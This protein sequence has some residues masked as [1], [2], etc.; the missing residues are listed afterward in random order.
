MKIIITGGMGF[1]G[2]SLAAKLL[3][4]GH[5]VISVGRTK[6]PPVEKMLKGLEYFSCN[7]AE[8]NLPKSVLSNTDVVFH[9]AA[10]AGVGG[11]YEEYHSANYLSTIRILKSCHAYG[12]R[13]FIQT[14]T[15]SVVF[16]N[17]PIRN[18]DER[19]PYVESSSAPYPFTKALAEKQVLQAH[20]PPHFQ[21]ISLRPHLVWGPGDQHLLP[22]VLSR[23]RK[24]KLK[25]IGK[26][27][28]MVDLT[29]ID[30]VCH[31][32]LLVMKGMFGNH[33]MGGKPYF[34]GQSEPVR[35]WDWINEIFDHLNL[36][37]LRKKVSFKKAYYLG[38]LMEGLWNS[39]SLQQDPPMTRFVASQL[40]HDHWFSNQDALSDFGYRPIISMDDAMRK[41]LPWLKSL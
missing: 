41:T 15:P 39:L 2:N 40:A 27:D 19:L 13:K 17:Q 5:Q 23:H 18:G 12:V 35:L 21:T 22:R 1:I 37:I 14:S 33:N 7:L 36:P 29:H 11:K 3:E 28:N 6:Q 38:F 32:H 30:N 10:K 16:S 20:N 8:E 9:T 31:A 25:I 4:E 24:G 26:G 34:I